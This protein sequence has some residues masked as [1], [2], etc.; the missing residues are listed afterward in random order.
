MA[1]LSDDEVAAFARDGYLVLRDAVRAPLLEALRQDTAELVA[2]A[3][4][5]PPEGSAF[6]G[7]FAYG[8]GPGSGAQ[9]LRRVEYVIDKL[10]ACQA[11]LVDEVL[12]AVVRQLQGV[13]AIPTWDSMVVK[14]PGDGVE[15]A[16]HR[17]DSDAKVA[18]GP[19]IF[20]VDVYLDRADE[21]TALWVLPGSHTWSDH[22]A[23]TEAFRRME[24]GGFLTD[25]AIHVPMAPGDVL[26]HDI[27]VLHGSP[28]SI[29]GDLR[30]VVYYEF[31]PAATELAVGPHTAAYVDLKRAMLDA[32]IDGTAPA[33]TG[34][35]DLRHVHEDHWR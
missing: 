31:R 21:H 22:D 30:R 5:G 8:T 11:L 16:W 32:C 3:V 23:W 28:P 25:G 24:G 19:P 27:R 34:A 14:M 9:V 15:V 6:P 33:S 10:A 13:D 26:L 29:G 2:S 1:P 7:D 17:D 4:G 18:G 35:G 12:L 20:N